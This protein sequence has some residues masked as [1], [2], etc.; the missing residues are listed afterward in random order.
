MCDEKRN[1]RNKE[2]TKRK[3]EKGRKSRVLIMDNLVLISKK[4][5][6]K[7]DIDC[8]LQNENVVL[9]RTIF[10]FERRLYFIEEPLYG[11]LRNI[12]I[13]ILNKRIKRKNDN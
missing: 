9:A 11:F 7:D 1:K 6:A 13:S 12:F 2:E 3:K 10:E 4:N 5:M 8:E